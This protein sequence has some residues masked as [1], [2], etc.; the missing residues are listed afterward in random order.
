MQA[1]RAG[2]L[3]ALSSIPP[4]RLLAMREGMTPGWRKNGLSA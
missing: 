2:G 4:L 3:A 1:L